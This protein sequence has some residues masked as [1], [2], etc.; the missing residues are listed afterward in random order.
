MTDDLDRLLLALRPRQAEL[1]AEVFP[2]AR[3]R[4]IL[5]GAMREQPIPAAPAPTR[6]G[7]R[8]RRRIALLLAPVLAA[9]LAAVV[10]AG[11][12]TG[13]GAQQAAGAVVFH[14]TASGEVV[15]IVRDPF[16][17]QRQLD[18]AFADRGYRIHVELMPV[19]PGL[20]G[21][22]IYADQQSG[23]RI[24]PLLR[25]LCASGGGGDCRTVGVVISRSY[26]GAGT[27]AL[28]R[29]ARAGESYASAASAFATGERLHC[30][31]LLGAPAGQAQARLRAQGIAVEWREDVQAGTSSSSTSPR[32]APSGSYVWEGVMTAPGR[33]VLFV[34]PRPW[35]GD[36]AHGSLND[37]GCR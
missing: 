20:V 25:G 17:A 7:P 15:A 14:R 34:Q 29:P 24:E 2:P 3:R 6:R 13:S 30:S 8:P 19:P 36:P 16:V 33:V 31:G 23:G 28:G 12:L 21:R 5:A 22:V 26:K 32:S 37:R 4:E 35:P 27:I 10:L 11:A 18:L 9:A 1:V